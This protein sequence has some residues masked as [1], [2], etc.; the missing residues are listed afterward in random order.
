MFD[1]CFRWLFMILIGLTFIYVAL[2]KNDTENN[3]VE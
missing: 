1:L 3:L 2:I